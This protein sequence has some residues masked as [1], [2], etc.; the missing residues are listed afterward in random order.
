MS[1]V[2]FRYFN[3]AG[4]EPTNY[5]LG[6]PSGA[7]HIVASIIEAK[8]NSRPFV[9][10]GNDY[11]TADKTCIR[12]YVHVWDIA[13][14]HVKAINFY[15]NPEATPV[16]V[17]LNLGTQHGISNQEIIN[18]VIEKYGTLD[19][20]HGV[21]RKGDPDMLVADASKAR[22]ILGWE[23]THSSISKIVDTAYQWYTNWYRN[24]HV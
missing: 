6:Q 24:N 13:D 10:N 16:S 4:A 21:R 3:A 5:D 23:P 20:T 7:S 8:L 19:I 9:L 14:A 12:D 17:I 1:S 18:Y 15:G 22:T 2:C 11:N